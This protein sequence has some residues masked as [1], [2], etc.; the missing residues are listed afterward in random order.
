ME[1]R[2]PSIE[3]LPSTL[4]KPGLHLAK[5]YVV[6]ISL[7][8]AGIG[9]L[10]YWSTA[11]WF[12]RTTPYPAGV[13]YGYTFPLFLGL[14]GFTTMAPVGFVLLMLA[15][16]HSMRWTTGLAHAAVVSVALLTIFGAMIFGGIWGGDLMPC[17]AVF[18]VNK[19]NYP[20]P[21]DWRPWAGMGWK[22]MVGTSIFLGAGML[23][24]I[25]L[26][27]LVQLCLFPWMV[28]MGRTAVELPPAALLAVDGHSSKLPLN[29]YRD[30]MS[31]N[32][33]IYMLW[34]LMLFCMFASATIVPNNFEYWS[35]HGGGGV[36]SFA[37]KAISHDKTACS[38]WPTPYTCPEFPSA[39]FKSTAIDLHN[40]TCTNEQ[41]NN[42]T[43][44]A[45]FAKLFPSNVMWYGFLAVVPALALSMRMFIPKVYGFKIRL[46][47][48]YVSLGELLLLLGVL[49]LTV[50]WTIYWG[51]DHNYN[52]Y[53]PYWSEAAIPKTSEIVARCLGQVAVLMMSLLMLPVTR[54]S[55]L[56]SLFGTS[57]E[58]TLHLH[59]W[60]GSLF[61]IASLLHMIAMYWW[62][63]DNG[64]IR[65]I[66]LIPTQLVT[67]ADNFTVP[68]I[69]IILWACI[70]SIGILAMFWNIRRRCYE[71]FL[72]A[73]HVTYLVLIPAVIWHAQAAWE[74]LLPGLFLWTVDRCMRF[75]RSSESV[76][77]HSF[78]CTHYGQAGKVT[79]IVCSTT[80]EYFPGQ[81]C[82]ANI[83]EVSLLEWHPFT[84]SSGE[85]GTVSFHIK[86][87]GP[88]SFTDRLC[89]LAEE[90]KMPTISLEGPYG[91]P[92]DFHHYETVLL[93]AGGIGITPCKSI[94]EHLY[95]VAATEFPQLRR[96]HLVWSARDASIFSIMGSRRSTPQHLAETCA[97][98][99]DF[100]ATKGQAGN[101]ELGLAADQA[102]KPELGVDQRAEATFTP[103]LRSG[104]PNLSSIWSQFNLPHSGPTLVFACG[105]DEMINDASGEAKRFG[106]DMHAETFLL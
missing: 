105:P 102:T 37:S 51:H 4:S 95:G 31:R 17:L 46:V 19:E 8:V 56:H 23:L 24:L 87:M 104:R 55:V 26:V 93:V 90:G 38:A 2:G 32:V 91:T 49:L 73:H 9:C 41:I 33:A 58:A 11:D 20:T 66:Y 59:R 97:F 68:L 14:L 79:D 12:T 89:K 57:W 80:F 3:F 40:G 76:N 67:A 94:M 50:C 60:L 65:D 74:F 30:R 103:V 53:W 69:Q 99:A 35:A 45:V 81:Y 6:A 48:G 44:S 21:K 64:H 70:I 92:V 39:Y 100:F 75:Y 85:S 98:S 72:Y 82:F 1:M 7:S 96:V 42:H 27:R 16:Q 106:W 71:V 5:L 36:A 22:A 43:C 34:L 18:C 15:F 61:L 78:K 28:R 83:A 62:Y 52:G 25:T 47:N 86:D 77:V 101:T 84:I 13:W 63:N 54:G 88:G 29:A 10:A